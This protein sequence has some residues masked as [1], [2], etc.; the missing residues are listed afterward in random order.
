MDLSF[1]LP[2]G[3]PENAGSSPFKDQN[4]GGSREIA[5]SRQKQNPILSPSL[6]P[7]PRTIRLSRPLDC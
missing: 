5:R 6:A 7:S 1:V 4:V 3:H 2:K